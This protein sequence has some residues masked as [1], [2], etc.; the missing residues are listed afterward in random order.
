MA[1]KVVARA[2]DGALRSVR[3]C[4]RALFLEL[5]RVKG[6]APGSER[7]LLCSA[8]CLAPLDAACSACAVAVDTLTGCL[9][10]PP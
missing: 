6:H 3:P 1:R 9:E 8:A 7:T 5:E 4:E 10:V 2:H